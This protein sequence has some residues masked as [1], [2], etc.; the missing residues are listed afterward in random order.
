MKNLKISEETHTFLKVYCSKHKLK[1]NEWTDNLILL[2]FSYPIL[3]KIL[4]IDND[5]EYLLRKINSPD[6]KGEELPR[7]EKQIKL[8]KDSKNVF[9]KIHLK[10]WKPI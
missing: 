1:I 7:L 8:L 4:E 9:I 6:A 3:L 5:I 10:N 2:N